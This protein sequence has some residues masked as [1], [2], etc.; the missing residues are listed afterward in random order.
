MG[1]SW[2]FG[3]FILLVRKIRK[4]HIHSNDSFFKLKK[5]HVSQE[6]HKKRWEIGFYDN[7]Q[8]KKQWIDKNESPPTTPKT[9]FHGR[10]FMLYV[11]RHHRAIIHFAF[12]KHN[13]IV[14]ADL[15]SQNLLCVHEI[16]SEN[17]LHTSMGKT[18]SFFNDDARS[19][20]ARITLEKILDFGCFVLLLPLYSPDFAPND[21]HLFPSQQNAPSDT[22]FSQDQ[23]KMFGKKFLSSKLAEFYLRRINTIA[24]KW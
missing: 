23:S 8:R 14:N 18:L 17:V 10:N 7:V 4:S 21:I 16:F 11:W 15:Y 22:R 5:W 19:H 13:Q 24:D 2:A 6:Y 1:A 20:S 12:L 3:F 9:E